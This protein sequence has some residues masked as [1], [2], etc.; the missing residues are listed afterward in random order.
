MDTGLDKRIYY[1]SAT[2]AVAQVR[3][4]V[5]LNTYADLRLLVTVND[6]RRNEEVVRR[7]VD[8]VG[9]N[10]DIRLNIGV[11]GP[12]SYKAEFALFDRAGNRIASMEDRFERVKGPFDCTVLKSDAAGRECV[13]E[14]R[15][16]PASGPP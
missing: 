14:A 16:S 1:T 9:G 13:G 15:T 6:V 11:L 4:R 12:G 2:E 5:G 3:L 7:A 8:S 10:N